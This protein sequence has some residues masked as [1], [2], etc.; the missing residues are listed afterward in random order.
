MAL[1]AFTSTIAAATFNSNFDDKL[2]ALATANA[3]GKKDWILSLYM[4]SVASTT[5]LRDRSLAWTAPDD[6]QVRV[7][8]VRATDNGIRGITIT[9]TVEGGDEDYLNGETF[10]GALI[11]S[12]G[13]E[14]SRVGTFPDWTDT[15]VQVRKGVRYRITTAVGSGT[16]LGPVQ[17]VLQVRTRR[18][19]A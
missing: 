12:N 4:S 6:A 19:D 17:V 7:F 11:T 8:F 5:E 2:T 3:E 1:T 15:W 18:R 10:L 14:D 9:L 13:T 16:V